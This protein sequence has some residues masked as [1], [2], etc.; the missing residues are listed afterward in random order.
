MAVEMTITGRGD[1]LQ[2]NFA[3]IE[4]AICSRPANQRSQ[5]AVSRREMSPMSRL[6]PRGQHVIR[7]R[8]RWRAKKRPQPSVATDV[9]FWNRQLQRGD[10][11]SFSDSQPTVEISAN[12]LLAGGAGRGTLLLDIAAITDRDDCGGRFEVLRQ[13]D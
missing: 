4:H 2:L 13:F 10:L 6:V 8:V 9:L 3:A 7:D 12:G 1:P 5:P 11:I